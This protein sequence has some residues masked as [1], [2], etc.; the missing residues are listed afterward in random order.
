MR[1]QNRAVLYEIVKV[2][3]DDGN[4]EVEDKK[5]T[6]EDETG[7]E[8]VGEVWSTAFGISLVWVWIT[9]SCLGRE[10]NRFM[11]RQWMT[12]VAEQASMISCQPS[13]VAERNS[14][15]STWNRIISLLLIVVC[16]HLRECLEIVVPVYHGALSWCNLPKDLNRRKSQQ[17]SEQ[18]CFLPAYQPLHIWRRWWQWRRRPRAE[19]GRTWQRWRAGFGFRLPWR[20]VWPLEGH[21]RGGRR[22]PISCFPAGGMDIDGKNPIR[23][24]AS[25]PEVDSCRYPQE[26]QSQ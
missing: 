10:W 9:D 3:H 14:R 13:P 2:I 22:K 18:K 17:L 24:I 4:K 12:G 19:L 8:E 15:S 23:T 11:T 6:D 7:K 20:A 21:G 16:S 26:T 1:T 25:S 5:A